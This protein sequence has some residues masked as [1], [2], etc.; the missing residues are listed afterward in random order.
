MLLL[1]RNIQPYNKKMAVGRHLR[2][3]IFSIF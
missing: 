2:T 1:H 3:A